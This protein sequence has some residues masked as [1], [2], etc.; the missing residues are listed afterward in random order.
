MGLLRA[1]ADDAD[2]HEQGIVRTR[3][4]TL[5]RA[6]AEQFGA[7]NAWELSEPFPMR[8]LYGGRWRAGLPDALP[9]E[10]EKPI[11]FLGSGDAVIAVQPRTMPWEQ[12]VRLVDG[13]FFHLHISPR[14]LAS[15]EDPGRRSFFVLTSGAR[16]IRWL[17]EQCRE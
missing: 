14:P 5:I 3:N 13:G 8:Y 9:R 11:Y 4:H 7:A 2:M 10:F 6:A 15:F 12:I 17:P 1:I 16:K